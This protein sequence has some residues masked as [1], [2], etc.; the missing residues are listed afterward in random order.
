MW[1]LRALL[2]GPTAVPHQG[3]NH[4]PCGSKS[5]LHNYETKQIHKPRRTGD[6]G[7]ETEPYKRG[8][9][10]SGGKTCRL[11]VGGSP[12]R[13]HPGSVDVNERHKLYSALDKGAI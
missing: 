12:V 1:G 2:K 3:S 5:I 11:A 9:Y 13:S 8:R 4:R 10:G 7:G 6:G